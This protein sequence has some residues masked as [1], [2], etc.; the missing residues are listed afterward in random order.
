MLYHLVRPA[1]WDR[2]GSG[3]SYV[4]DAY[5]AEGFI[6]FS[7]ETQV[8]GVLSRYFR[9]AP[10]VLKLHLD[11]TRFSSELKF[12]PSTGGEAF[13]HLYGPLNR[14]A[15]VKIEAITLPLTIG[16]VLFPNLTQL[17]F[18]GPY[19]V[20]AR[21]PDVRIELVAATREPVPNERGSLRFSPTCTFADCPPLDVLVVPGGPGVNAML[22]DASLLS[23][24]EKQG[25]Q[26]AYVTSVCTGA[27]LLAAAGLLA[28]YRATT[29]WLS[30][31]LLGQ[32]PGVEAV[33]ERVVRDRNR[34]TGGGVTAGID[35]ALTLVAEWYGPAKAQE[36]QLML[37]YHPQPPF[38]A[39]HPSTAPVE[40]TA[41]ART[42]A[43]SMLHARREAVRWAIETLNTAA[44]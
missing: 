34:I 3:D 16:F 15:I 18:T 10:Q 36:I 5:A 2:L 8:P 35:F 40:V 22:T 19:D 14:E 29:H 23:F 6:H 42:G 21:L 28:G 11:E 43:E 26:A 13:P 38:T 44:E 33:S 1:D 27:L 32:F 41:A 12:E 20:L 7:T 9:G 37:E 25:T 30:L 4:P 24:L 31:D 17:D 39:G